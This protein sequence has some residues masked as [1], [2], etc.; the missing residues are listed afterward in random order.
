M[1]TQTD[2]L[3]DGALAFAES[4]RATAS[5]PADQIR[6]LSALAVWSP[7]ALPPYMWI[8]SAWR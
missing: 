4:V 5:D 7:T 8:R 2:A 1:T 6:L 3:V